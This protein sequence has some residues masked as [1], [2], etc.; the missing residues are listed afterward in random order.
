MTKTALVTEK[1]ARRQEVILPRPDPPASVSDIIRA[2]TERLPSTLILEVVPGWEPPVLTEDQSGDMLR[3]IGDLEAYLMPGDQD[4]I[5][6][7]IAG[8]LGH[9][10]A[11]D[12]L[13]QI[14][15]V[16]AGD[17]LYHIGR[18]P[19]WA[20][21]KACADWLDGSSRRPFINNIRELC[22]QAAHDD[23]VRLDVAR[24]AFNGPIRLR[25]IP[26]AR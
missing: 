3:Y 18:Y 1:R 13:P 20:V 23:R 19:T 4:A 16:V 10:G 24:R 6:L 15:D 14:D 17:W 12:P 8:L 5:Q 9:W 21:T 11:A 2:A 26:D 7:R 22:D 25:A